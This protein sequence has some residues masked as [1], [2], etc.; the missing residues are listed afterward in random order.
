MHTVRPSI[1]VT[2]GQSSPALNQSGGQA[3]TALGINTKCSTT[4]PTD[5][6][7]RDAR[8]L[9]FKALTQAHR[10]LVA[11]AGPRSD[12]NPY[13]LNRYRTAKCMYVNHGKV[14]IM[15]S[16]EH[17][18]AHYKGLVA[19]GSVWACP[20]CAAKIQERRRAE[21]VKAIAWA[22]EVGLTPVMVTFTFPH[23]LFQELKPMLAQQATAFK[24]LREGGVWTR[25]KE[26][27]GYAGLIR[28]LEV[29]HGQ[30]G[31][32]PHTHELWFM[33]TPDTLS[34]ERLTGLWAT[35][36][37]KAGLL[38]DDPQQLAA[39]TKR[40]VDIRITDDTVGE[41]LAKQDNSR[42]WG[43]AD[44]IAKATS[45]AGKKSGVH[46]HHFLV[47][48]AD[49]DHARFV[50]FVE[51]MKGKRQLFWTR[52]LKAAVGIGDLTDEEIAAK[53]DDPSDTLGMLEASDWRLIRDKNLRAE[54]LNA[55]ESGGWPAVQK[56]LD[57]LREP[58]ESPL[59]RLTND[60]WDL[61]KAN[62]EA[63]LLLPDDAGEEGIL[64]LLGHLRSRPDTP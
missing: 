32:H 30:N 11:A 58:L 16:K 28:S 4:P 41:Y 56:I 33:K 55:A 19:C 2:T 38:S 24:K 25:F 12:L 52:G 31:W 13:P 22:K 23:K 3:G 64:R 5:R 17:K 59:A 29:T 57:Q 54:L 34:K 40:S 50:E 46:P 6:H 60:D 42:A 9:R 10:W 35:A 44:E 7:R 39:F 14:S 20:V 51:G 27:V 26:S 21:I 18:T 43:A 37:R 45:K 47:R 36:C 49:G 61:I 53:E 62:R 8:A 63:F 1:C 15:R 48:Q